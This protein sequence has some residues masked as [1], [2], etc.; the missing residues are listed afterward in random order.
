MAYALWNGVGWVHFQQ[1]AIS[2]AMAEESERYEKA[3]AQLSTDAPA[4][5]G[6]ARTN[7]RN[8]STF[9]SSVGA[10][11][12]VLPPGPLARLSIGQS[13]LYPYYLKVS[14]RSRETFANNDE[15]ENPLNLMSGR[16]D[17]SFVIVYL[18]PLVILALSFNL[19]SSEREQGTFSLLLSQPISLGQIAAGKVLARAAVTVAL[20][21]GVSVIAGLFA[22]SGAGWSA[23]PIALWCTVV[24]LYGALWFALAVAVN[25]FT[26]ASAANATILLSF[27]LL[28][29]VVVPTTVAVTAR[30]LY[31]VPSRVQLVQAIRDAS[32]E[33]TAKGSQ[34]LAQ[35][36]EDHPE[37]IPGGMKA[38]DLDAFN[39]QA[40]AVQEE[41]SRLVQPVLDRYDSQL[42]KQQAVV[43]RFRFLSPAILVQETLNEIAGT[44]FGRYRHFMMQVD[45]FH[46]DWQN[47]FASRALQKVSMNIEAV[48]QA[49]VFAF[50]ERPLAAIASRVA[51]SLLGLA[52]PAAFIGLLAMRRMRGVQAAS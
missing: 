8:P 33:A 50:E 21:I 29:V 24:A 32:K 44:D 13:D 38:A 12:A 48:D 6:E 35:Y 1:N 49:P 2:Q 16:F 11:Y 30:T 39:A 43:D 4:A 40:Y 27:W 9:G 47:Y 17:L 14:S 28:A 15:I 36:F 25:A 42:R 31:P 26:L 18:F 5:P 45:R 41:T 19:F 52:L 22:G 10:R 23:R 37:M 7:P 3:R 51:A 46:R 20:A 34:L